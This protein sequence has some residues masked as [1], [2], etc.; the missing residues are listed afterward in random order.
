MFEIN[1]ALVIVYLFL[2]GTLINKGVSKGVIMTQLEIII[3]LTIALLLGLLIGLD[4]QLKH[5]PLGLKTS[6]IICIASCLLTIV[7]IESFYLFATPEYPNMDPMRLTA[8]IISGIGFLGAGVIL[9]RNND[10]V[11]GLTS[12]ALIWAASGLGIAIGVGLY[13]EAFYATTLFVLAVN[14]LPFLI[15]KIGPKRLK[16]RDVSVQLILN[17]NSKMTNLLK[18]IEGDSQ[19]HSLN[20]DYIIKSLKIKDVKNNN[21]QINLLISAPESEYTTEIYYVFKKIEDVISVEIDRL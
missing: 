21:Q 7:S 16:K 9:R 13:L 17:P 12:A 4:R 8:Q 14:V 3:K 11:S 20:R 18:V 1:I 10:V 6:M 15:K 19:V 5:K 2:E